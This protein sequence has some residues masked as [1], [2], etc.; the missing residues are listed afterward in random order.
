MQ[1]DVLMA[2]HVDRVGQQVGDYRLLRW[3]GGGG[4]GDVYLG[5]HLREHTQVAVKVLQTRLTRQEDLKEFIN[6]EDL[7]EFINEARTIRLKHPHIVSLLDFG[8]ASDNTPFLVMEYAPHGSLRDRYPKGSRLPLSMIISYVRQ[9]AS[10][11][12]YAHSHHLIHRDVKPENM[13]MGI[14]QEVLLSDFGIVAVAHRSISLITEQGFGGT[15]PYMA[16]EQIAGKPQ[17]ASDQYALGIVVYEWITGRRPFTGNAA[18]IALQH[19]TTPPPSLQQQ[20]PT[21]P[22]EVEQVV[23]RAL[24]KEPKNRF[25]D[26]EAFA[27]ALGQAIQQAETP[28]PTTE[29]P[30]SIRSQDPSS[31]RPPA[32]QTNVVDPTVT[33]TPFAPMPAVSFSGVEGMALVTQP[34]DGL[35]AAM[36]SHTPSVLPSITRESVPSAWPQQPKRRISRRAVMVGLAGV[37][38]VCA[39]GG[40]LAWL[41]YSPRPKVSSPVSLHTPSPT[42]SPRP[43]ATPI[44]LGNTF[45]VCHGHTGSVYAAPYSP[46][47][48]FIASGSF[49]HT[50][51]IWDAQNGSHVYTYTGHIDG[52]WTVAWS[53]SGQRIASGSATINLGND[54]TVQVWN[55]IDGGSVSIYRGHAGAV[56]AVAWSPDGTRIASGGDDNTVQVW[57]AVNGNLIY[58]YRRISSPIC[59]ISWSPNGTRIASVSSDLTIQVWNA[60]NGGYLYTYR[61][62]SG[63][64]SYALY[65]AVSWSPDGTRI[66]SCAGP[67]DYTVQ[68]WR[69]S[70]GTSLYTYRGHSNGVSTVAWS[71]DGTRIASGSGFFIGNTDNTVQVWLAS[72]GS[73]LYTYHGHFA[74]V[75][76]LSWSPNG[77]RIASGGED[78]TVR[79]WQAV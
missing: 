78:T 7:K 8:I 74:W 29:R 13:L 28:K 64:G 19:T 59:A 21:L 30:S 71:P 54:H 60:A 34:V 49:D 25:A 77:T 12:Q 20:I 39:V 4:F 9:L 31:A 37:T 3:L 50:V 51:R 14:W 52:V 76:T 32:E 15:L 26:I 2:E 17:A 44:T 69:A 5:E 36:P 45:F 23:M 56:R 6:Q 67:Y 11:L 75:H 41:T 57:N 1:G 61:G 73:H 46:D 70:D 10:A 72:N 58:T 53:P 27:R 65:C 42:S 24:E 79:V 62:H 63:S 55:A 43:T 16:P 47:G 48:R 68:V 38:G 18:E 33:G 40:G 66:A 22:I 35:V